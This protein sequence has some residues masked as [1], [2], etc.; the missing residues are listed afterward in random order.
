[1][2]GEWRREALSMTEQKRCFDTPAHERTGIDDVTAEVLNRL[3]R[4]RWALGQGLPLGMIRE[5]LDMIERLE[6][7]RGTVAR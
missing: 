3:N 5:D 7:S 4:V 6:R 2:N 1:M